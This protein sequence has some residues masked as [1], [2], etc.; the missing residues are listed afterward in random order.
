MLRRDTGKTRRD[1]GFRDFLVGVR[2]VSPPTFFFLVVPEASH[3]GRL[4]I[5]RHRLHKE[6]YAKSL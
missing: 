5:V 4:H 2:H 6:P 3:R 1:L